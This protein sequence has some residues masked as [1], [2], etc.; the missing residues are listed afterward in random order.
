M[1]EILKKLKKR[2]LQIFFI[3]S[4]LWGTF[5]F[6]YEEIDALFS[7]IPGAEEGWLHTVAEYT[8]ALVLFSV[9]LSVLIYL[10]FRF[11]PFLIVP[12]SIS[13]TWVMIRLIV[14]TALTAIVLAV[15]IGLGW[16]I[17]V[18]S[19]QDPNDVQ[20]GMATLSM[21]VYGSVFLTPACTIVLVWFLAKSKSDQAL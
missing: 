12:E 7:L 6:F 9:F 16:W 20:Y 1:K 21:A 11:P 3:P 17:F 5:M 4:L 15:V 18:E 19:G 2:L 8:L 13:L 10:F 14:Y